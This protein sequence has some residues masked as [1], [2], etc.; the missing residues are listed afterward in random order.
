MDGAE[1]NV[2][3]TFFQEGNAFESARSCA[4]CLPLSVFMYV[5]IEAINSF[6]DKETVQLDPL[7]VSLFR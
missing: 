4:K 7:H 6:S 2:I 3:A 5:S 1:G